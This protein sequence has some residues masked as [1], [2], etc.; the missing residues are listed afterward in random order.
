MDRA[1]C[2]ARDAPAKPA[3][4]GGIGAGGAFEQ[5]DEGLVFRLRRLIDME[6]PYS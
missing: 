4:V 1:D 6:L 5:D 3:K 2:F